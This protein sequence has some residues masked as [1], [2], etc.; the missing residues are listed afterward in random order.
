M[1]DV[2]TYLQ[3]LSSVNRGGVGFLLAYGTT[4][5]LA[6]A[7]WRFRGERAGAWA[8]LLQ[9]MVGLPLALVLTALLGQGDRPDDPTMGALSVY[10][11]VGQLLVL[12]LAAVLVAGRRHE[13][14]VAALA[15]TTAVH[16][17]PYSWLYL[18]PVYV[19]V[20]GVVAVVTASLV[21]LG[22]GRSRS[23]GAWVCATTGTI[24]LAGAAGAYLTS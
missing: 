4:W 23:V 12:P 8:A 6:G 14:A 22:S 15:T 21:A 13:L 24:L 7:V 5:V 20:G 17:V 10:L 9:G 1:S 3:T 16:L 11:G 2:E 19:I 18:T